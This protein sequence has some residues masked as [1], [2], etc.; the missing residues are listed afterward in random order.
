MSGKWQ[1]LCAPLTTYR[2]YKSWEELYLSLW[3]KWGWFVGVWCGDRSYT[4]NLMVMRYNDS[5]GQIDCWVTHIF[6]TLN[7]GPE[8]E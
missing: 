6:T 1:E 2:P 3:S 4:G 5:S 7:V 8:C